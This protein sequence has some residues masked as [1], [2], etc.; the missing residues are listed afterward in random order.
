GRTEKRARMDLYEFGVVVDRS[1]P[2]VPAGLRRLATDDLPIFTGYTLALVDAS[3]TSL[4]QRVNSVVKPAGRTGW[5]TGSKK[6]TCVTPFER[7][8]TTSTTSHVCTR[9]RP[10][11]SSSNI[12]SRRRAAGTPAA[13]PCTSRSTRSSRQ[14]AV[15][16]N[17]FA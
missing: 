15:S 1:H 13:P 16:T 2:K 5:R 9:R 12:L 10:F 6:G 7:A 8:P 17:T 14:A 4:N 11:C 3:G